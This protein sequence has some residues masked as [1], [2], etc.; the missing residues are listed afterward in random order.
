MAEIF[1]VDDNDWCD[2][3]LRGFSP[4]ALANAMIHLKGVG[5]CSRIIDHES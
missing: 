5:L 4:G 2:A 3:L 1:G